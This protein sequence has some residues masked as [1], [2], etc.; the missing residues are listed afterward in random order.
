MAVS[1]YSASGS[2]KKNPYSGVA[3]S[4]GDR[5]SL[6]KLHESAV[7][8]GALSIAEEKKK[9]DKRLA[10]LETSVTAGREASGTL[11]EKFRESQ[12]EL[13]GIESTLGDYKTSLEALESQENL[14]LKKLVGK[15]LKDKSLK[16]KAKKASKTI[17]TSAA[18]IPLSYLKK[19]KAAQVGELRSKAS[20]AKTNISKTEKKVSSTKKKVAGAEKSVNLAERS[21][22]FLQKQLDDRRRIQ[23]LFFG[24]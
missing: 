12:S 11:G 1:A 2:L 15:K 17:F 10:E 23:G 8:S 21:T 22:E 5:A 19:K 18:D 7:S 9:K 14:K 6:M 24:K 3:L 13:T 16:G 4:E 20:E